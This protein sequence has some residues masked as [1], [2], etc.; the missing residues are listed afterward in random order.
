MVSVFISHTDRSFNR[1][2]AF[3]CLMRTGRLCQNEDAPQ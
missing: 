1:C 3:Q 2:K